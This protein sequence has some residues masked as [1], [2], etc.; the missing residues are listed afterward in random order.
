LRK[1]L[2]LTEMA[3]ELFNLPGGLYPRRVVIYLTEKKLLPHPLIKI[4]PVK[5]SGLQNTAP[6]K[7]PGTV[8]ILALG[9]GRFIKQSIAII[10]FFEDICDAA[11]L[12]KLNKVDRKIAEASGPS[13]RGGETA[14]ERARMR[15]IL[16]LADEAT[17]HF[18]VACHKGSAL[19]ALLER[20][21]ATSSKFAMESCKKVLGLIEAYYQEDQLVSSMDSAERKSGVT[22]A[23]CV[24]FSLLQFAKEFYCLDLAEGLPC[25]TRFYDEFTKRDSAKIGD[26]FY[27]EELKVLASHFIKEEGSVLGR[28]WQKVR[29]AGVYL[30][31]CTSLVGGF[32]AHLWRKLG[33]GDS[34]VN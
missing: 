3:Y 31:V 27:T 12:D 30:W 2:P 8:P 6:G 5:Q 25:L 33:G 19:M 16:V 13:M 10:E 1:Y 9:D 28:A 32:M 4:T 26:K 14:A 7:P 11:S 17:T 20:Q 18:G 15:E 24:L 21:D 29:L 34:K 22:I 23:D